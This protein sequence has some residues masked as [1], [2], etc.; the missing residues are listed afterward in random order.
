MAEQTVPN[1]ID[2]EPRKSYGAPI[3]RD[4]VYILFVR[5]DLLSEDAQDFENFANKMA[6]QLLLPSEAQWCLAS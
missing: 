6:Q 1:A 2:V 4:R 5:R 3:R